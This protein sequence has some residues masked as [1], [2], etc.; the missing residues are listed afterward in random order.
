MLTAIII[1]SLSTPLLGVFCFM[2]GFKMALKTVS[3]RA[4]TKTKTAVEEESERNMQR[5]NKAFQEMM[6]YDVS[7]AMGRKG[8]LE[9]GS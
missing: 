1:L 5:M 8:R 4:P 7:T 9:D 3:P 2:A 6:Q